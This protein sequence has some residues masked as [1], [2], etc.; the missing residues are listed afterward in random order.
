MRTRSAAPAEQ[1]GPKQHP[2][3][4][5]EL[6]ST[7]PSKTFI[8]PS[9]ATT[10]ARLI[11]LPNP[12][13][14]DL[15]SY[16]FCPKLGVYEFT[17]VK[18]PPH[19]P[20]SVLFTQPA[21]GVTRGSISKAAELLVATPVDVLFFVIPLLAPTSSGQAKGLFQPLDDIIDSQDELPGHLRHVLY[22]ETFRGTLQSRAEAIC[23]SVEAGDEKMLRFS[24]LK[25]L[26]ELLGKT[27]RMVAQGLPP[28]LEERFIRQALATP[29]LAVKREDAGDNGSSTGATADGES[30]SQEAKDT[31]STTNTTSTP[32]VSTPSGESA[33]TPATELPPEESTTPANITHLLRVS[34][35]LTFMKECYLAEDMRARIDELLAGAESPLDFTPLKEHLE[36]LAKLRAEALASRSLGDFSRKRTLEDE[37]AAESRAEKKRRKEEEEKKKKAGQSRGVRELK[38]VDTSGMKKMSDFFGKAATKKKS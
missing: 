14:G 35:A 11:Q 21:E 8:L 6:P 20:R 19:D 17:V 18:T 24:E 38:K 22:N 7:K 31:P 1:P 15:A 12:C 32:S 28:S 25:L 26:K 9:A 13:T 36:Q 37:D 3:Q 4:R 29:L 33:S 34:T 23:D 5:P 10:D 2:E 30:E 27:E 16:F